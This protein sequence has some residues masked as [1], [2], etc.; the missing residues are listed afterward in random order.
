MRESE[1][2]T[3][4]ITLRAHVDCDGHS[5]YRHVTNGEILLSQDHIEIERAKK[6]LT[7]SK[8]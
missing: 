2:E 5:E 4:L 8:M 3:A 6:L 7:S 1:I